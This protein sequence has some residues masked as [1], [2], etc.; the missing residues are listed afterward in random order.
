MSKK[1]KRGKR[2]KAKPAVPAVPR[3]NAFIASE[4]CPERVFPREIRNKI[5]RHLLTGHNVEIHT[6]GNPQ[7]IRVHRYSF[8]VNILRAN[9]AI[10]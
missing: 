10:N 9:R 1:T 6:R 4:N 2:G 7:E 5:Y 8:H 3:T